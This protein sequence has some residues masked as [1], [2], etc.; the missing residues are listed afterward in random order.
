MKT[1]RF[2][3]LILALLAVLV[4]FTGC[5]DESSLS[6]FSASTLSGGTFTQEDISAKDVTV[7]NFWGTFCGPCLAEMPDLA[8]YA[9]A[10]PENVQ[11]VTVCVDSMGNTESAEAILKDAGFEGTTLLLDKSGSENFLALCSSVQAVP[12]TIFM[13]SQGE[14]VGSPLVGSQADLA[15]SFTNSVNTVLKNSGKA[16]ITVEID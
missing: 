3:P 14:I 11:L 7:M 10:L 6:A 5:S 8:A 15:G 4:L 16:E 2:S 9:K 13:N 1:K 12:T